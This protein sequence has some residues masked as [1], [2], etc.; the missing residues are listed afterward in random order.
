MPSHRALGLGPALRQAALRSRNVARNPALRNIVAKRYVQ[1]E[2]LPPSAAQGI[3]N[4]QRLRRPSSPHFTIYQPQLTWLGS[5]ANRVTGTGISV[6]L[7]S[8][9]LAYL[10]AP[11]TFSSANVVEI[12]ASLPES[13]KYAG[14]VI[15]AAPFAFHSLNGLR[16]LS[17]DMG[18]FLTLKGA[19]ASGYVV[20]GATA[21]ST[22]ALVLL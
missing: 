4:E 20:L 7:Y 3:L 6:L 1:T 22:I 19:Y 15:L 14:K 5:I 13:V 18:R 21:V 10:V 8:Y 16:H 12:I 2:S 17:W 9:A 11:E